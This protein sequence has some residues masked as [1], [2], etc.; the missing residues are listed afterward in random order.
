MKLLL[1]GAASA[2][3]LACAGPAAAQ[4]PPPPPP[5]PSDA[6][7]YGPQDQGQGAYD[8]APDQAD[9]DAMEPQDMAPDDDASGPPDGQEQGYDQGQG[10]DEGPPP[11]DQQGY[12]PPQ[13]DYAPSQA[14]P[15]P[16]SGQGYVPPGQDRY[17]PAEG[18]YAG[19]PPPPPAGGA[20]GGE[21]Q[22]PPPSYAPGRAPRE[23]LASREDRLERR[24]RRM[25]D[26]GMVDPRSADAALAELRSIQAEQDGLMQPGGG[27][28][29]A[30]E[31]RLRQR[32]NALQQRVRAMSGGGA[33]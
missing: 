31:Q 32:L 7:Q 27:I 26:R 30:D 25:A 13:Q 9:Q 23:D 28:D 10:Y 3:V 20:Y 2:A 22:G 16:Q 1:I 12:P 19:P 18:G 5:P 24:I 33:G 6:D 29:P 15:P 17:G 14:Y 21:R 8:Q 11:G 4:Y